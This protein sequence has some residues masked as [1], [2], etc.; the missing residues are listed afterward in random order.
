MYF[1]QELEV[2]GVGELVDIIANFKTVTKSYISSNPHRVCPCDKNGWSQ[3]RYTIDRTVFP[4]GDITIPIVVVGQY[5]NIVLVNRAQLF[6]S[7]ETNILTEF[8]AWVN[9]DLG[10]E[11]CFYDGVDAYYKA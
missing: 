2:I 3:C 6:P 1:R 5:A 11:M 4:G 7:G 9:L 10:I 8:I